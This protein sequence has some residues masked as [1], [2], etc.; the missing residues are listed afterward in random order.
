M[1]QSSRISPV[2][3]CLIVLCWK[4]NEKI[5]PAQLNEKFS[6]KLKCLEKHAWNL[7]EKTRL[8]NYQRLVQRQTKVVTTRA[9]CFDANKP[10]T[11]GDRHFFS[12]LNH[13]SIDRICIPASL[14]A[15]AAGHWGTFLV[16]RKIIFT[17]E[18]VTNTSV[19]LSL[20]RG[21]SLG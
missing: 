20:S 21:R 14:C 3:R 17:S 8:R 9:S 2:R 7:I 19:H 11:S 1:T 10:A 13:R 16:P 18:T 5:F 4:K 12:W 6:W 15:N